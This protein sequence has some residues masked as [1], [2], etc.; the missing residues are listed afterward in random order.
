MQKKKTL[1]HSV[2]KY[3]AYK[4]ISFKHLKAF[5]HGVVT[6]LIDYCII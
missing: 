4:Q 6:L 5:Y 2:P 3:I 1:V